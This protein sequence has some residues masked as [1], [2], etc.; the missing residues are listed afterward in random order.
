MVTERQH[1]HVGTSSHA[2]LP[3]TAEGPPAPSANLTFPREGEP[4][5]AT[6]QRNPL[7]QALQLHS[8]LESTRHAPSPEPGTG[9]DLHA[10]T[11]SHVVPHIF[12][13]C[14]PNGLYYPRCC[15]N[16]IRLLPGTDHI[17]LPT[18]PTMH[19]GLAL[20]FLL[21]RLHRL[22]LYQP[23]ASS[24]CLRQSFRYPPDSTSFAERGKKN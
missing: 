24:P 18:S 3:G 9:T 1:H 4:E 2:R 8:L 22:F 13:S 20:I 21:P 17:F 11:S 19:Q 7:L 5:H 23:S 12:H 10:F 14:S 15:K 16:K 6:S